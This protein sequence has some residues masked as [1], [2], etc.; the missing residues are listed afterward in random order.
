MLRAMGSERAEDPASLL[1][2][3]IRERD[4]HVLPVGLFPLIVQ[5]TVFA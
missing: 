5:V 3:T 4:E 1:I 2:C